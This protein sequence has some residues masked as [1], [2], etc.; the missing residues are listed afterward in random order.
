MATS[1]TA[2][3]SA[4]DLLDW[5]DAHVQPQLDRLTDRAHAVT[6]RERD[7]AG[8]LWAALLLRLPTPTPQRARHLL[9][10]GLATIALGGG[11]LSLIIGA[12][13]PLAALTPALPLLA[14]TGPAGFALAVFGVR[15]LVHHASVMRTR[16]NHPAGS[17][18]AR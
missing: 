9:L 1:Y 6:Q 15:G 13:A 7:A 10:A 4:R 3:M 11:L 18:G 16:R 17:G 5:Y 2:Q 8:D 14:M 12:G